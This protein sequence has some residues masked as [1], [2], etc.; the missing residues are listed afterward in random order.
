M[1]Y[2]V[3]SPLFRSFL[4]QKGGTSDKRKSDDQKPKEQRPKANEN[5]P[6]MTDRSKGKS[7]LEPK[8]W[9]KLLLNLSS[10][11]SGEEVPEEAVLQVLETSFEIQSICVE[12]EIPGYING[13]FKSEPGIPEDPV[14]VIKDQ[15]SFREGD[16][17]YPTCIS[18]EID[19][20]SLENQKSLQTQFAVQ[21]NRDP[22]KDLEENEGKAEEKTREMLGFGGED[23][24]GSMRREREWKR[25]LA[26]KL[27]EERKT[28]TED[29]EGM[30]LL[31]E[32]HEVDSTKN[33]GKAEKSK[34]EKAADKVRDRSRSAKKEAEQEEEEDE[35]D[36]DM[37][38]GQLCCLQ[39]LKF[40]TGKMNLGMGRPS[41]VKFSKR[42]KGMGLF[43][44]KDKRVVA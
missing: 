5:K 25:T 10:C 7:G 9:F 42:L 19:P 8:L 16:V 6:V 40:T 27:Y 4:S 44:R 23:R 1:I 14:I 33:K 34:K 35:E 32:V 2:D 11:L 13:S 38:T 15:V 20:K 30:D 36:E 24:S 26:C 31:W 22:V 41:L 18:K 37:S 21:I 17:E 39:A 3:N 29:G 43:V 12:I 28:T